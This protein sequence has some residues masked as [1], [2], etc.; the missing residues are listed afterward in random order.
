MT[1]P[2]LTDNDEGEITV[3]FNERE[4]R[5]WSY[6]DDNTRRVKIHL[7]HEYIEGWHDGW[8]EKEGS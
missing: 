3:S 2:R 5:S 6:G 8:S 4:L 7:A 1:P